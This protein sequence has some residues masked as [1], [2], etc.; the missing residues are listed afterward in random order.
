M[1]GLAT[2]YGQYDHKNKTQQFLKS[3]NHY[4]Q[5]QFYKKCHEFKMNPI[6][7]N[8][9]KTIHALL[10]LIMKNLFPYIDE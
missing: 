9:P 7:V 4:K 1:V 10:M 2:R 3:F 6:V 8:G 5:L